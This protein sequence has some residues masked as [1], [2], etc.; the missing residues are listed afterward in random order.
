MI[1][2][3]GSFL[4]MAEVNQS[5]P[6]SEIEAKSRLIWTNL[7]YS[8][9]YL[10]LDKGIL[11]MKFTLL[12]LY[13]TNLLNPLWQRQRNWSK[14]FETLQISHLF[15]IVAIIWCWMAWCV[16]WG[17]HL[18][19]SHG[20]KSFTSVK[21]LGSITVLEPRK[22]LSNFFCSGIFPFFLV[23]K[24]NANSVDQEGIGAFHQI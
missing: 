18:M 5:M 15:N 10:Q 12:K 13:R 8:N 2:I 20:L 7:I 17:Y 14:D 1:R 19:V 6:G 21:N 24:L 11:A 4:F 9:F 23:Q 3:C 22:T 16:V